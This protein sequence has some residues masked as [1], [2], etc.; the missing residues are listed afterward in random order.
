MKAIHAAYERAK[1]VR[2]YMRSL[3]AHPVQ[4]V[5]G[6]TL[7]ELW[8]LGLGTVVLWATADGWDVYGP[9][10]TLNDAQSTFDALKHLS[11]RDSQ[12][13]AE[14]RSEVQS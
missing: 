11:A 14:N 10:C 3:S 8:V 6:R 5:E 1:P 4:T 7:I 13:S 2:D 9:V 12:G